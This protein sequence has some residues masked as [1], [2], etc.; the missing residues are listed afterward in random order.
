MGHNFPQ[1]WELAC[2]QHR[3]E[4]DRETFMGWAMEKGSLPGRGG[5]SSVARG[6]YSGFRRH[7]AIRDT[8]KTLCE[9]SRNHT[10]RGG[11]RSQEEL[12]LSWIFY[13]S[14]GKAGKIRACA[15]PSNV[16]RRPSWPLL[17]VPVFILFLFQ[18]SRHGRASMHPQWSFWLVLLAISC[19]VI[20]CGICGP[21]K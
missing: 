14:F 20:R 2:D 17:M 5:P 3:N 8:E 6:P 13:M 16:F 21:K 4:S 19:Q 12:L 9:K 7:W 10:H 15:T 1:H 18:T 11:K